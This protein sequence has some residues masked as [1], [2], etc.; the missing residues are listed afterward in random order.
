MNSDIK[1][2]F[3]DRVVVLTDKNIKS[4]VK[5]NDYAYIFDNKKSLAK[6]LEHF[7]N[8]DDERLY[9]IH[10]NL[11]EL[12]ENIT[13]CFKYIEAAGGLV[14]LPDGRMLLIRRL[15]KWDLPKGKAEKGESLRET[16]IRE[17]ME[18]CGL[19]TAPEITGELT[20]TFH[21]YH[22][23]GRHILKHT[24]WYAMLY[25]G[26]HCL[27]PQS[28]EDITQAVWLPENRL[29]TV[30][31]DTYE[32]IRQVIGSYESKFNHSVTQSLSQ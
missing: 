23:K 15:D 8:S 16:A 7:E 10:H 12:F 20:H 26:D 21:T 11:N 27:Q 25:D 17:V 4:S 24:A 18:E 14:S 31:H 29:N 19:K 5:N 2:Y 13:K 1:I 3:N 28:A 9:V 32:T 22:Q 30:L 6:R